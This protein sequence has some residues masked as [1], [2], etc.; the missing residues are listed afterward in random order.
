MLEH[1]HTK[2]NFTIP[3]RVSALTPFTL[4]AGD[5]L[6]KFV[7]KNFELLRNPIFLQNL[8]E[9]LILG[10][11]WFFVGEFFQTL[12]TWL[13]QCRISAANTDTVW[14]LTG[15]RKDHLWSF[16]W[17]QTFYSESVTPNRWDDHCYLDPQ[18]C[19][20]FAFTCENVHKKIKNS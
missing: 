11:F 5:S 20:Y 13:F 7:N 6:E 19:F 10:N 1:N 4:V 15:I 14:Q 2:S 12:S 18:Q 9:S 8:L 16:E 17:I 3:N